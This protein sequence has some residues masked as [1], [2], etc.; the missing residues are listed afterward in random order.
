MTFQ[1]TAPTAAISFLESTDFE[2]ANRSIAKQRDADTNACIVGALA[3]VHYG[4]GPREIQSEIFTHLDTHLR[5]AIVASAK[6]FN[7]PLA[8]DST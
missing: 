1:D 2:D 6:T 7:I 4:G 3:E 5:D 8:K